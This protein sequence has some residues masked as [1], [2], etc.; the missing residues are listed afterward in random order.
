[1]MAAVVIE[2]WLSHPVLYRLVLVREIESQL[3][4]DLCFD[5]AFGSHSPPSFFTGIRTARLPSRI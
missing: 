5:L 3:K 1:L 4:V 2:G